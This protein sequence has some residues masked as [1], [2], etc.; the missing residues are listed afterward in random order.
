MKIEVVPFNK[1]RLLASPFIR[2]LSIRPKG[3]VI[4]GRR[5]PDEPPLT[6]TKLTDIPVGYNLKDVSAN[7]LTTYLTTLAGDEGVAYDLQVSDGT[8]NFNAIRI[9]VSSSITY[10]DVKGSNSAP[11]TR[12]YYKSLGAG[13]WSSTSF[14]F[15]N[16]DLRVISNGLVNIVPSAG[17]WDPSMSTVEKL[18]IPL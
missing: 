9:Y 5:Q 3:W 8:F 7:F 11:A 13:T 16:E 14:I 6:A 1:I 10:I 12:I 4:I 17:K 15:P 18:P 2:L